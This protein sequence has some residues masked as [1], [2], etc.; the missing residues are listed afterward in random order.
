MPRPRVTTGSCST[1]RS[2]S[3]SISPLDPRAAE[4]PLQLE[5]LEV[6]AA[7]EVDHAAATALTRPPGGTA[8]RARD[9]PATPARGPSPS[10]PG[11]PE[12]SVDRLRSEQRRHGAEAADDRQHAPAVGELRTERGAAR[13]PGGGQSMAARVPDSSENAG[14]GRTR[15]EPSPGRRQPARRTP[16]TATSADGRGPGRDRPGVPE[17]QPARSWPTRPSPPGRRSAVA[18]RLSL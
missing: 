10:E 15:V 7:A 18:L 3:S 8:R 11:A 9:T 13:R 12:Q 16:P 2:R 5:H 17:R 6:G 4:P 14:A 1:S